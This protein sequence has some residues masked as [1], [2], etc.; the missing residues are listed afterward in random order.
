MNNQNIINN[1]Y[2]EIMI[3]ESIL[4]IDLLEKKMLEFDQVDC[5]VIHRFGPGIYIREVTIPAGSIAIGHYQKCGHVN[6]FLKG[7]ITMLNDDGSTIDL[8]APMIF[9][10]KPGRKCGY[11]HED[12]VWLNIY[13]TDETD[14]EILENTYLDKS[15]SWKDAY[16][17]KNNESIKR[18]VDVN[19]YQKLLDEFGFT[20]EQVKSQS[21]NEDDQIPMP[22]GSYKIA[23]SNSNINGKGVFATAQI[24]AN[25]I[26][27]PAR[28][29]GKRTPI[30]RY[31]NHSIS[32]NAKMIDF[33]GDIYLVALT[34]INGCK[35]G[36]LGEEI[37]TDYRENLKLIGV[38]KCLE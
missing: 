2:H 32:P 4:P 19:D 13:S 22:L 10:G 25:E 38:N 34:D 30:G 3:S 27:G 12:V 5:P 33:N 36:Y 31:V 17:L 20:K 1:E 24:E 35:G 23:V 7:K 29:D 8:E 26:I 14:V 15:Q 18:L 11:I 16:E 6:V 21:E 28:I 9:N 37:T